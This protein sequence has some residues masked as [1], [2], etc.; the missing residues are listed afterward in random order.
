M[1]KT[2][3]ALKLKCRWCPKTSPNGQGRA[4]H[5]RHAHPTEYRTFIQTQKR[6]PEFTSFRSPMQKVINE[7]PI[8]PG[9]VPV[10][11]PEV[12]EKVEVKMEQNTKDIVDITAINPAEY[13]EATVTDLDIKIGHLADELRRLEKIQKT[14]HE[15]C[16]LRATLKG[17]L[18]AMEPKKDEFGFS[19]NIEEPD[20]Q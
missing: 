3:T 4:A 17:I 2:A 16:H 9:A 11:I 7:V 12:L 13:I 8:L 6:D 19:R 15:L 10:V 20:N 5:E 18:T 14:H 1:S